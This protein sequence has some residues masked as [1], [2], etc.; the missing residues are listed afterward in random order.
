MDDKVS[1]KQK[2]ASQVT[3]INVVYVSN[4]A[5]QTLYGCAQCDFKTVDIEN[6]MNHKSS[7]GHLKRGTVDSIISTSQIPIE[8]GRLKQITESVAVEGVNCNACE[9]SFTSQSDLKKHILRE[10][11]EI[12]NNPIEKQIHKETQ[13]SS[14]VQCHICLK[15]YARSKL[16]LHIDRIHLQ[17]KKRC[18]VCDC[19]IK[20]ADFYQHMIMHRKEKDFHCDECDYKAI[21]KKYIKTHKSRMHS[22]KTLACDDCGKMFS[23]INMFKVHKDSVHG[24]TKVCPHCNFQTTNLASIETHI[25]AKHNIQANY[26]C[27][28]CPFDSKDVLEIE[29]HR[30]KEHA[31]RLSEKKYKRHVSKKLI[32]Y[33]CELCDRKFNG[34]TAKRL[35]IR[36]VHDKIVFPCGEC[37]FKAKQRGQLSRHIKIV[38]RKIRFKCEFCDF[39]GLAMRGHRLSHHADKL[40]IYGCNKCSYR[41]ENK[42]SLQKHMV[43]KE[44]KHD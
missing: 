9:V 5:Y 3:M 18:Y 26:V 4:P 10:H 40:K 20:S 28:F 17:I 38:H 34:K 23:D 12:S 19:T 24:G 21:S 2:D 41:S 36:A 27:S 39:E 22:E 33:D 6:L 14:K 42:L 37:N 32:N 15:F 25:R 16:K 1:I 29:E 43:S 11:E 8:A 30:N 35:H 44:R 7:T 13:Y 31:D